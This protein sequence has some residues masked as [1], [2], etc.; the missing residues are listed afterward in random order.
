[1]NTYLVHQLLDR[2]GNLVRNETRAGLTEHGLQ[3]VQL[4]ALHYLAICCHLYTSDAAD[5]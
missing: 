3:P 4:D 5:E 2:I 1:M